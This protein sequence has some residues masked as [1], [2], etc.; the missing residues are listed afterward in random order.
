MFS[1]LIKLYPLKSN[2]LTG[3][4]WFVKSI[5]STIYSYTRVF[6]ENS[7]WGFGIKSIVGVFEIIPI[8]LL[9]MFLSFNKV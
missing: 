5:V 8:L 4:C 2:S 3:V 1:F 6:L 7:N 9:F